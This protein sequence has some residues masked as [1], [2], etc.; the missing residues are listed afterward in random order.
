MTPEQ[1]SNQELLPAL[2]FDSWKDTLAT[3]H[4]WTQI[5]GKVRLKL[6]P[7]VNHWW[8]VP[9]YVTARGMTTS[10]M[11]YARG[12]IRGTV[13]VRFDFI[14]HKLSL[15]TSDGRVVAIALQA[16]SVAD[17]YKKF[18]AALAE[19]GVVVKIWTTPCEIL[20]PIPFERDQVH[21]AYDPEAVNKF[22]RI[23][24]WVDPILKEFRAG[25]LG[26]VSPVH[27]FWGG[28]DLAVT[29]FS[30][31]RAPERPG[32]DAITREGYSHEVSSAG[33][34]AGGGDIK[35]PAFY[36]YAAPEPSGFAERRVRP[37]AAFYHPQLKEFLLMYDDVRAAADPKA[38]LME[39]LHSTYEAAAELGNWDRQALERTY[40]RQSGITR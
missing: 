36:S 27:F 6:C 35:G 17:F 15:E 21:A 40:V 34:W 16:Q 33:F 12:T 22:W 19:L 13:E 26:K 5:V 28:F 20:D 3:L 10:A 4:M 1:T 23:L 29:R 8:N 24:V 39:F 30:G 31:R 14:E 25:F 32:A 38:A 7:L 9:F 11:P 18:M 2:P 37:A